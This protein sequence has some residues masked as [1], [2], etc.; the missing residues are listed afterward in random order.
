MGRGYRKRM[1]VGSV[2]SLLNQWSGINA[3]S[4]YALII[5]NDIT[6]NNLFW[7]NALS[8]MC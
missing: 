2:L 7:N 4:F 3:I 6:K 8:V 5:F 1:I